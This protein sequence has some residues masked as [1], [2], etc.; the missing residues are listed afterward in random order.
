MPKMNPIAAFDALPELTSRDDFMLIAVWGS[1]LLIVLIIFIILAV[2]T[3]KSITAAASVNAK[4]NQY[5]AA[6]PEARI[7]TVSAIYTNTKKDLGPA[8]LL[9]LLFGSFGA[10]KIYLGKKK[11][12][13]W[14]FLLSFTGIPLLLSLFDAANMAQT[15]AEYN[16]QAAEILYNQIAAPQVDIAK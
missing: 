13:V 12:A 15:V 5:L 7:G 8:L 1:I 14:Y 3:G 11:S 4:I 2:R 9:C 6:I 16:L 10:H